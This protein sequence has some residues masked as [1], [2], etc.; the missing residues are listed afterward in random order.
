MPSSAVIDGPFRYH[1]ARDTDVRGG[2]EDG[3]RLVFIMLNPSVA[4][5]ATD[6]HTIRKCRGFAGRWGYSG[7][8]VVNLYAYRATDPRDLA[9]AGFPVGCDNDAWIEVTCRGA[10]VVCA[11]GSHADPARAARVLALAHSHGQAV[12]RIGTL[13]QSGQPRHPLMLSY[14]TERQA[15]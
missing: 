1:L 10:D 14:E 13:T 5:E 7:F 2:S 8:E 11:W 15:Q 6:D 12:Y 9:R 4:D 3:T